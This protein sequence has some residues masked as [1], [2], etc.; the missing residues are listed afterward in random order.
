MQIQEAIKYDDFDKLSDLGAGE[1]VD[2]NFYIEIKKDVFYT[3]LMLCAS[4]GHKEC[5][6]ILLKNK[7]L[8][9]D[10]ID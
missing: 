3:P 9:I 10:A 7:S 6:K 2:L 5:I 8:N 1:Q 4:L